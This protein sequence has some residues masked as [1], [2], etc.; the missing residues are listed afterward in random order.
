MDLSKDWRRMGA[1][2]FLGRRV[3]ESCIAKCPRSSDGIGVGEIRITGNK[4]KSFWMGTMAAAFLAVV[5]GVIMSNS[6]L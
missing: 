6:N 5:A 3:R 1:S 4:W 2:Q